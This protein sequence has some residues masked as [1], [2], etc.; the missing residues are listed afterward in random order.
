MPWQGQT[1]LGRKSPYR[2]PLSGAIAASGPCR[3]PSPRG[4]PSWPTASP[5]PP[6]NH[7]RPLP[8]PVNCLVPPVTAPPSTA[9]AFALR[10]TNDRA[11]AERGACPAHKPRGWVTSGVAMAATT[12]Q[13]VFPLFCLGPALVA[14]PVPGGTGR[15][16]VLGPVPAHV[17]HGHTHTEL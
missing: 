11:S 16:W 4:G 12:H 14:S 2:S 10:E 3:K 15:P 13:S 7:S 8:L 1:Y 9:Q 17:Q 5:T 6:A